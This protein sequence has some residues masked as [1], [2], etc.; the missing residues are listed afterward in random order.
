MKSKTSL[1][2]VVIALVPVLALTAGI[3]FAN[4]VEP[5]I[6]GLPFLPAYITIWIMLTP[7]FMIAVYRSERRP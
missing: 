4:R 2:S 3:P 1:L 7:G 5:R 6:I